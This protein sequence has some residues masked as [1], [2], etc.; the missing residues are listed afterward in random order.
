[1]NGLCLNCL[2][3]GVWYAVRQGVRGLLARDETG[4]PVAYVLCGPATHYYHVMTS[5]ER[6]PVF[7]G[8]RL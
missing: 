1:V 6:G 4:E 2:E 7:F 8:E 5:S 3:H